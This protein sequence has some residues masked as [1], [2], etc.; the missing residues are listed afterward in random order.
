MNDYRVLRVI[1]SGD[2]STG[3]TTLTSR[4]CKKELEKDCNATIGVE[5]SSRYLPKLDLKLNIWDLGGDH[6]FENIIVPYFK[7]GNILVFVYSVD[8]YESLGRVQYLYKRY[9][10]EE[11]IKDHKIVVVCNK[12]DII[13]D[14]NIGLVNQGSD[15]ANSI[16]ADFISVSAKDN[17]NV[18]GLFNTLFFMSDIKIKEP[19]KDKV[20]FWRCSLF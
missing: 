5:F 18:D 3:K 10:E 7:S 4:L 12:C 8:S 11:V 17:T 6:R 9:K 2:R 13:K 15:W 1:I 20:N 14:D 19:E 16:N